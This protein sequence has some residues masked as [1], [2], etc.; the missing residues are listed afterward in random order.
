M[1]KQR[2][3]TIMKYTDLYSEAERRYHELSKIKQEKDS[4]A[5]KELPGKIHI[6]VSDKRVKYYLRTDKADKTG[7][8]ISKSETPKLKQYV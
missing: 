2:K 1:S 7:E 3:R 5:T 4:S 6:S 8:Y